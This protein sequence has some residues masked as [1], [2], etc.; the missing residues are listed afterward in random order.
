VKGSGANESDNF[1]DVEGTFPD[2]DFHGYREKALQHFPITQP[3]RVAIILHPEV[4]VKKTTRGSSP[5][6]DMFGDTTFW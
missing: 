5:K 6:S 1:V 2:E 3:C 4:C